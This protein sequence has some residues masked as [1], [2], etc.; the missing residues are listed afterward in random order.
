MSF[1]LG[2]GN[3]VSQR[4]LITFVLVLP[5]SYD[6]YGEKSFYV[7]WKDGTNIH[8]LIWLK[9]TDRKHSLPAAGWTIL[10]TC[11]K[12]DGQPENIVSAETGTLKP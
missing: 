2:L 1:T 4:P 8:H 12:C 10:K 6:K 3:F 5:L 9:K 11:E 7:T